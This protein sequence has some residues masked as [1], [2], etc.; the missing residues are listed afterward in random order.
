MAEGEGR[1]AASDND[2][3]LMFERC[4]A[5]WHEQR[6]KEVPREIVCRLGKTAASSLCHKRWRLLRFS[7]GRTRCICQRWHGWLLWLGSR[8]NHA[9]KLDT[10]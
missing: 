9:G 4:V 5:A 7:K 2:M 10:G 3:S 1:K 6:L 8:F